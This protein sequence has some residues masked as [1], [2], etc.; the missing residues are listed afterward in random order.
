MYVPFEMFADVRCYQGLLECTLMA[1]Q[2]SVLRPARETTDYLSQGAHDPNSLLH[3][4]FAYLERSGDDVEGNFREL[5]CFQLRNI[6]SIYCN[7]IL[8]GFQSRCN[9]AIMKAVLT[10]FTVGSVTIANNRL[11]F[12]RKQSERLYF[13]TT[14][15]NVIWSCRFLAPKT[16]GRVGGC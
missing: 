13:R 6:Y 15:A 2:Q 7:T 5:T 4:G 9:I 1:K 10:V 11:P 16:I 12:P 14:E 3:G 8:V